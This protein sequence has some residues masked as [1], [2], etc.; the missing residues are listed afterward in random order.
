MRRDTH[1]VWIGCS[2]SD[3]FGVLMDPE[4]N[5]RWQTGVVETT[6]TGD[7]QAS[8]G[9]TMTEQREFAGYRVT[10]AYRLVELQWAQRAVVQLLEGPLRGT[11]SYHCR[12]VGGG[13]E[14]TVALAVSPQGRWRCAAR[15]VAAVMS[16]ELSVSCQRLKT[17]LEQ[18]AV[19]AA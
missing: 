8:V 16:A 2:P 11:A 5:R 13:T 6:A 17:L 12:P 4:A 7:G 15:A 18:P 1:R 3:V 9:M 14:L 19:R 10:I